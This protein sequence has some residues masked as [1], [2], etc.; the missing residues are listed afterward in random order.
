MWLASVINVPCRAEFP[1]HRQCFKRD[2]NTLKQK[3]GHPGANTTLV[4]RRGRS[5]PHAVQ[6]KNSSQR[7]ILNPFD[8]SR[9]L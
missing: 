5:E 3:H 1:Q 8:S 6:A 7:G 4:I 9:K 2:I